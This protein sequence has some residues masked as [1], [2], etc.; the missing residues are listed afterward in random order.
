MTIPT[1][2]AGSLPDP[3]PVFDALDVYMAGT[4]FTSS[5]ASI[6]LDGSGTSHTMNSSDRQGNSITYTERTAGVRVSV[7]PV[8]VTLG[9]GATQQFQ[10]SATNPDGTAFPGATFTWSMGAG[11]HGSVDASGLYTAPAS[12]QAPMTDMLTCTLTGQQS[13]ATVSISLNP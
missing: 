6:T 1:P 3:M 4:Q 5:N 13:W 11:A 8:T 2:K 12:I 10:A 9:P 7:N